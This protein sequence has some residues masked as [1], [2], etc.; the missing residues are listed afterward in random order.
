MAELPS[1]VRMGGGVGETDCGGAGRPALPN[2]QTNG[3]PAGRDVPVAPNGGC[4][5]S[6]VALNGVSV[7]RDVPV[8][9]N[10]KEED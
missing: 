6:E 1:D 8:A 2:V 4:G 3:I 10:A 5:A 9:P 7:G